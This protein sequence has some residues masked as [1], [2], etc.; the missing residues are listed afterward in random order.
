[1]VLIL[2]DKNY[3]LG[4]TIKA[5]FSIHLHKKDLTILELIKSSL[6]GVGNISKGKDSV[7]YRVASI[8]ELT[9]IIIPHFIKYPLITQKQ[10]DFLLFKKAIELINNKEHLTLPGLSKILSIKAS[11][12]LGLSKILKEKFID[13]IPV[14]RPKRSDKDLLNSKINPNWMVGFTDAEG[15]FNVSIVKRNSNGL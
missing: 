4:W 3:K 13:I 1:M 7:Q 2:K 6:N 10:A 11:M 12:N 14:E 15:C 5:R 9:N 8:P